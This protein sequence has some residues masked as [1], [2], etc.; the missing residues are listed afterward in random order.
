VSRVRTPEGAL[1]ALFLRT[2]RLPRGRCFFVPLKPVKSTLAA[3]HPSLI[4]LSNRSD[5]SSN[6][7]PPIISP[8]PFFT[9]G[10]CLENIICNSVNQFNQISI[11]FLFS[12]IQKFFLQSFP[13]KSIFLHQLLKYA[14][15]F[16]NFF[17]S[18]NSDIY[19]L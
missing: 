6:T 18:E 7:C 11:V 10:G 12:H 2:K 8:I 4:N 1:K 9:R 3:S 19:L 13:D 17:N 14:I 15:V 16:I 5:S